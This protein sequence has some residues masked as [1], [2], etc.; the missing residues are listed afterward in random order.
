MDRSVIGWGVDVVS[1]DLPQGYLYILFRN[2]NLHSPK[3]S[4]STPIN[5]S[6]G[7]SL[8]YELFILSIDYNFLQ[9]A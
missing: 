8:E 4:N 1:F 7:T 3:K 5:R 2:I 9:S 6:R